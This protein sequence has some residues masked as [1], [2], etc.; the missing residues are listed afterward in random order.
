MEESRINTSKRIFIGFSSEDRYEVVESIL[1][2]LAN[3]GMALWYDR[4]KMRI[5][6]MCLD[7]FSDGIGKT[8]YAVLIFS[9]NT[10]NSQCFAKEM[11][12]LKKQYE[13]KKVAIFPLLYKIKPNEIHENFQWVTNLIYK[14]LDEKSGSLLVCNHIMSRI[15]TDELQKC[16][17]HTIHELQKVVVSS[18][19]DVFVEKMLQSY[20]DIDRNN[21]NARTTFLFCLFTYLF[22][23]YDAV[24]MLPQHYWRGFNR[25]F[26][27]TKLHIEIEQREILILELELMV[28]INKLWFC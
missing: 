15:L 25:V 26:S 11:E 4:H 12:Y 23:K 8:E 16:K 1:Y 7:N 22:T 6:D 17:Y 3:Y 24:E 9:K 5:G 21:H 2:H 19:K 20:L 13:D 27:Y 14:K 10:N 18:R 28:L